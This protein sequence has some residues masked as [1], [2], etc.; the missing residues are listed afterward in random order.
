MRALITGINGFVGGHLSKILLNKGF[1][2][3]G[4]DIKNSCNIQGITYCSVDISDKEEVFNLIGKCR[5]D[6]IFHLAAVSSVQ[7]C[8]DNPELTEK[9]NIGGTENIMSACIENNINPKILIASSGHVY[10]I[11][12]NIPIDESHPV[13]PVN[14]YGKSKLEQENVALNFFRDYNLNIIISRSFN[15]IGPNQTTGFVCSDF[16]KQ[17]VEIEKGIK[18]PEINVGDLSTER[19]F[20]DVRDIVKAYLLLLEKGKS[21]EIYNIGSGKGYTIKEILNKLVEKSKEKIEVIEDKALF[22]VS[23]I[24]TL[25]ANNNKFIELTGWKPEIDIDTSLT[26]ILNYWRT[27]V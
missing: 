14:E 17:I 23:E 25:V 27:I 26:D 19:D 13:N 22:R 15:H 24:P 21:G 10:G 2:V 18:K 12:K 7:T 1:E 5:P 16:A 6:R 9:V 20:T 4:T 3:F 11:P 8:K